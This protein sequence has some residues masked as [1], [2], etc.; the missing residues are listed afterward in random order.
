MEEA[1]SEEANFSSRESHSS[2]DSSLLSE[3]DRITLSENLVYYFRAVDRKV[4]HFDLLRTLAQNEDYYTLDKI[5]VREK[6]K[7]EETLANTED[8]IELQ[9][10][11]KET[12]IYK[13]I[14]KNNKGC[15]TRIEVPEFHPAMSELNSVNE[16]IFKKFYFPGASKK[17][18]R[19]PGQLKDHSLFNWRQFLSSVSSFQMKEPFERTELFPF[20]DALIASNKI[21]HLRIDMNMDRYTDFLSRLHLCTKLKELRLR[22]WT[23]HDGDFEVFFSNLNKMQALRTFEF[24]IN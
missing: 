4:V 16:T 7:F 13:K 12:K 10:Q 15:L 9:G 24:E 19:Q 17:Q 3:T 21:E 23:K 14:A 1:S 18:K 5:S 22:N 20:T 11:Q 2:T 8:I 6:R